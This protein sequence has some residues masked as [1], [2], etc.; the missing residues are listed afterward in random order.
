M[1][2]RERRVVRDLVENYINGLATERVFTLVDLANLT[3]ME[4]ST[5]T[6]SAMVKDFISNGDV[7]RLNHKV[8]NR[9]GYKKMHYDVIITDSVTMTKERNILSLVCG[10]DVVLQY[11]FI[12][13]TYNRD[14]SNLS[15]K[16]NY[17]HIF[18]RLNTVLSMDNHAEW[19]LNY[20]GNY[21]TTR[22]LY[23]FLNDIC[24]NRDSIPATMPQG[25][26]TR[27]EEN[28]GYIDFSDLREYLIGVKYGA[29]GI[30]LAKNFDE[31]SLKCMFEEIGINNLT[32]MMTI[33]V[34][35]FNFGN[36]R[37]MLHNF[38]NYWAKL[39]LCETKYTVDTNRGLGQ[40]LEDIKA[41]YEENR[42]KTLS[43]NLKKLNFINNYT[44]DDY[45]VIVPQCLSDLQNEGRQQNNCVGHY[46]NS[47]IERGENLICFIRRKNNPQKSYIT[48]RY[49]IGWK[50]LCECR[51]KNN[52]SV[53]DRNDVAFI[54]K[55][56]RMITQNLFS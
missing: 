7:E 28:D 22:N 47:S 32:K 26:V 44:E 3:D 2:Q 56:E 19:L 27:I 23:Y 39:K 30:K 4:V 9:T 20:V 45:I 49:N 12:S 5:Q 36:T 6:L 38:L 15:I 18:E 16:D 24:R 53:T 43:A 10:A 54:K 48:C 50:E 25:Y 31:I 41:L 40:N 29:L 35:N 13:G 1:T 37:D 11:D 8:N 55:L 33:D 52:Y 17:W 51:Y 42:Y 21:S 46:Y 14:I 34:K